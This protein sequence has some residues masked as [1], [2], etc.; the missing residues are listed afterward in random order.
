[1][2]VSEMIKKLEKVLEESGDNPV[3]YEILQEDGKSVKYRSIGVD[4]N[5]DDTVVLY[6]MR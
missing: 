5:N 1:M 6:G 4:E 2:K 3:V